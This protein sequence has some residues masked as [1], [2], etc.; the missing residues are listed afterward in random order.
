MVTSLKKFICKFRYCDLN[1]RLP[2][3][4]AYPKNRLTCHKERGYNESW[5]DQEFDFTNI[6]A[7]I[8]FTNISVELT[9][10]VEYSYHS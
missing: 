8:Q 5:S 3:N 7:S 2:T 4:L 1:S 6:T 9:D 10:Y